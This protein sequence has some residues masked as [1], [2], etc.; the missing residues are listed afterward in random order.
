MDSLGQGGVDQGG[1]SSGGRLARVALRHPVGSLAAT[2]L[3]AVLVS[4]LATATLRTAG[5]LVATTAASQRQA[6]SSTRRRPSRRQT[7]PSENI[8]AL[9]GRAFAGRAPGYESLQTAEAQS[10]QVP[11]G[12]SISQAANTVRFTGPLAAITIVANPPSGRDMAFR[13]A[14]LENPT[15]EVALGARVAVRLVNGDDDSAHGWLLLDPVVQTGN[16]VHGPRAF[17]NAF[18]SILGDPTKAGQP[19]ETITFRATRTGTYRYEC[20]VPG[21][22]AMG[23]QGSFVVNA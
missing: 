8:G 4:V 14:G 16:T 20:P 15:I 3:V 1:Q 13:A 18:A 11:A 23:M 19:L 7:A 6:A 5:P 17:P 22:A 2:T 9:W 10:D 12:A 21:H